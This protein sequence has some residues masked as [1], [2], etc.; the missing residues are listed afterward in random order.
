[1]DMPLV[2]RLPL[3]GELQ[4]TL[5][6]LPDTGDIGACTCSSDISPYVRLAA[7]GVSPICP[8][9]RKPKKEKFQVDFLMRQIRSA[10]TLEVW[11]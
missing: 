4:A 1:M 9:R 7:R 6:P 2:E 5:L 8:S 3:R 11:M 10:N